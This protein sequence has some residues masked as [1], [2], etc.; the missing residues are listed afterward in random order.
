MLS[1]EGVPRI[2]YVVNWLFGGFALLGKHV[3]IDLDGLVGDRLPAEVVARTLVTGL[4]HLL[5]L[6][7]IGHDAVDSVGHVM[8]ELVWIGRGAGAVVQ[9]VDRH[10]ISGFA[11][12]DDFGN[13]AG[14][15]GHHRQATRHG[16][17]VHD[18]EWLVDGR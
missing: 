7:R 15:G 2:V 10:E 14:R 8:H 3:F 5:R 6:F 4:S 16:L 11:I 18:T 9:L 12:D 13:A 1:A 17:Q